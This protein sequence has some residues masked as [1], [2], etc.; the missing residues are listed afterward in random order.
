MQ[1]KTVVEI[2]EDEWEDSGA[3]RERV[4]EVETLVEEEAWG[5][6][7]EAWDLHFYTSGEVKNHWEEKPKD[8]APEF[9]QLDTERACG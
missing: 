3:L 1:E 8:K 7:I 2:K 5:E 6:A 9:C 4:G